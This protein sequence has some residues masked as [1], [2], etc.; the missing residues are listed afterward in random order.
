M[1]LKQGSQNIRF[2][3]DSLPLNENGVAIQNENDR[4]LMNGH[5]KSASEFVSQ[6][7]GFVK[8]R[9]P[10]AS[11]TNSNDIKSSRNE[12]LSN[13]DLMP[14]RSQTNISAID[15]SSLT[16]SGVSTNSG[17]TTGGSGKEGFFDKEMCI[18]NVSLISSLRNHAMYGSDEYLY[19]VQSESIQ[20]ATNGARDE[21]INHNVNSKNLNEIEAIGMNDIGNDIEHYKLCCNDIINA[22]KRNYIHQPMR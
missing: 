18:S 11:N 13:I 19:I 10:G 21:N 8:K 22:Y 5:K 15:D 4:R 6:I 9:V 17:Q 14:T 7:K 3:I 12:Y 1:I 16:M 2:S 20:S